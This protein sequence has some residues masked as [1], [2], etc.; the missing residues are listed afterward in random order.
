MF[1]NAA[2]MDPSTWRKVLGV[3]VAVRNAHGWD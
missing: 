3:M 1:P 2:M